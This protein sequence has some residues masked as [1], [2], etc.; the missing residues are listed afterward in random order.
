MG[1]APRGGDIGAR[2][3]HIFCPSLSKGWHD[4]ILIL[5]NNI[6]RIL[7]I[8]N[9]ATNRLEN[10]TTERR[11]LRKGSLVKPTGSKELI[12]L[13]NTLSGFFES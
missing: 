6:I 5:Q 12:Y 8:D 13:F 9:S 10:S 2:L 1:R 4:P 11:M 3:S 7:C